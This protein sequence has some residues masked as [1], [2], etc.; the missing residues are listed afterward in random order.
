MNFSLDLLCA[1][2]PLQVE[3]VLEDVRE[4]ADDHQM[5]A[6]AP[7][8]HAA[9]A[10]KHRSSSSK[11]RTR[12][13]TDHA[14]ARSDPVASSDHAANL[15]INAKHGSKGVSTTKTR[16]SE[17][18]RVDT[19]LS[20]GAE[21]TPPRQKQPRVEDAEMVKKKPPGMVRILFQ[22]RTYS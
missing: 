7:A 18:K 8:V 6:E 22:I 14:V 20:G 16:V 13:L 17:K 1:R 9:P 15:G 21:G 4:S 19:T 10:S 12:T 2:A 3:V 11:K 5:D